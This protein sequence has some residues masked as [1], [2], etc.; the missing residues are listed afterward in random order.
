[1]LK[2]ITIAALAGLAIMGAVA[3]ATAQYDDR[4]GAGLRFDEGRGYGGWRYREEDDRYGYRD[5]WREDRRDWRE[6]RGYAFDE[7]EYL[8]CNPD[9]WRAVR[10]GQMD[11]GLVHWRVFGRRE[12]R[13]LEC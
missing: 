10:R 3:P 4:G 6:R 11:S 1:M 2:R 13:R 9:V 7:R 12:G 5:R 8:R